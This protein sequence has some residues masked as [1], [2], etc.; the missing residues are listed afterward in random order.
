MLP[1]SDIEHCLSG[2]A[3]QFGLHWQALRTL[4]PHLGDIENFTCQTLRRPSIR[5]RTEPGTLINCVED[6]EFY[7]NQSMGVRNRVG[8]GEDIPA[9]WNQFL[10]SFKS[11]KILSLD[12]VFYNGQASQ[13]FYNHS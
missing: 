5:F 2:C 8:G 6:P 1:L 3:T 12:Q 13:D 9:R 4:Y 11:L 7:N 10:G